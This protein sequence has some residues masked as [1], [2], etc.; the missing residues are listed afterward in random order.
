MLL[1]FDLWTGPSLSK[2]FTYKANQGTKVEQSIY[3]NNQMKSK[4]QPYNEVSV[5]PMIYFI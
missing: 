2:Q 3:F 4:T 5:Y 1:S